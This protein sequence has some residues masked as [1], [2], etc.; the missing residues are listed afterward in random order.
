MTLNEILELFESCDGS[1][2]MDLMSRTICS[3]EIDDEDI[4]HCMLFGDNSYRRNLLYAGGTFQALIICWKPG[5]RSP[6]HDHMGSSCVLKVLKGMATETKFKLGDSG[7]A[8][9][10]TMLVPSGLV[11]ASRDM[12]IHEVA[13]EGTGVLVTLHV[14][15]PPLLSMGVYSLT[16]PKRIEQD[17]SDYDI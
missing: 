9:D 7:L 1:V 14:Y 8:P 13:N 15:S 17:C 11:V 3:A 12:D 5:Q 4:G 16:D 2:P 6:I 10:G